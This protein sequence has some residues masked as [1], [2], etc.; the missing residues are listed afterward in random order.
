MEPADEIPVRHRHHRM[1][2]VWYFVGI[3]LLIY[4]I[5]ILLASL[6]RQGREAEVVLARYHAGIWGGLLL[7]ALGAG[8]TLRFWPRRPK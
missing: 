5:I 3:L 1:L 6:S 8:Y 7:I 4:G 2:P